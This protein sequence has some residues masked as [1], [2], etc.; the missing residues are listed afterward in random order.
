MMYVN[1]PKLFNEQYFFETY[2]GH[3][4][5]IKGKISARYRRA[6]E[7]LKPEPGEKILDIG[8]GRGEIIWRCNEI[9][10]YAIGLD[11]SKASTLISK[12]FGIVLL[13]DAS[14]LPFRDN[15][16]YGVISLEVIGHLN[17]QEC[18]ICISEIYRILKKD[19]RI[20]IEDH[21]HKPT[22][23]NFLLNMYAKLRYRNLAFVQ[24]KTMK[25]IQQLLKVRFQIVAIKDEFPLRFP[26]RPISNLIYLPFTHRLWIIAHKK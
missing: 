25:F 1:K 26:P 14:Y 22:F 13:A 20:I 18:Y 9:G 23:V 10:C 5:F 21:I 19:G 3:D 7:F 2:N 24:S 11:I 8:C 6:L 16:F 4:D 15:I 12:N 17:T